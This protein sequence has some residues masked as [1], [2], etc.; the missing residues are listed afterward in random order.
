[1]LDSLSNGRVEVWEYIL[2]QPITTTFGQLMYYKDKA[3][4]ERIQ[5]E[6]N[7]R[8]GNTGRLKS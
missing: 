4:K 8:H 1:M 3:K 2:A 7:K 6:L 5:G